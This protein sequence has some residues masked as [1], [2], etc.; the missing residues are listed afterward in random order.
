M[1]LKIYIGTATEITARLAGAPAATET[2]IASVTSTSAFT[3]ASAT[4]LSAGTSLAIGKQHGI[5]D[6]IIGNLVN[7]TFPLQRTPMMGD[8]VKIYDADYTEYRDQSQPFTFVD[9]RK[10][11]GNTGRLTSQDL[12]LF[13][14]DG[15]MVEPMEQSRIAIFESAD[16]T[17]P[18]FAGVITVSNRTPVALNDQLSI[19][20]LI[21]QWQVTAKGYQAEADGVGIEEQP[22][23]RINAGVYLDY[24]RQKYTNLDIGY[25]DKVNSPTINFIR[26]GNFRRFSELG[27]ALANFWPGAEFFIENDHTR[28]KVYFRQSSESVAP[29]ALTIDKIKEIGFVDSRQY[30][31]INRDTE[32]VFNVVLLP[33]YREQYREPDFHVQT[34]TANE[35]FLKTSVTLSG[36]PAAIEESLLLF[37]DFSDGSLSEDWAE[38]DLASNPSPP[39]GF[40]SSDGYLVE[41]SINGVQGLHML[42][43]SAV[44]PTV[45]LGDIGR[46]TDPAV[47][48]PFTG[49]ERQVLFMQELVI[50]T[51]GECVI[52][53]VIDLTTV[54]TATISGSTAS[55]IQVAS[56]SG[57]SVDDRIDV[58]GQK[59]FIQAIG[60]NYFDLYTAIVGAPAS[61]VTVTKHRLAKSRIQFG[62]IAKANG[63]LKYIKN[64]VETAFAVPRT[65]TATTYSF[66]VY[67]R[68]FES[69]ITGSPTNSSC[70]LADASNFTTGDVVLISSRG[71]SWPPERRVITKAGSTISFASLTYTPSAGYRVQA[72]PKIM[73]E[74]KGGTFGS[75]TGRDWTTVYQDAN[76]WQ[77]GEEDRADLS[78][79]IAMNASMV[80][81]VSFINMKDPIPITANIES[82]Y[83]HIGTQEV[84]SSEKDVDCIIR[85]VG[86]HFQ[87]D[88]FQDT[89]ALWA[90][91]KTLELRYKERWRVH[92]ES[93]DTA[94]IIALARQRGHAVDANTDQ[95]TLY[96]LGGRV[97][98]TIEISPST[99]TDLEAINQSNSLLDAVSITP[100]VVEILT[101][102]HAD[103]LCRSGQ[104]LPSEIEGIPNLLIERVEITEY[105]G[106][107]KDTGES[108][109]SQR[110]IAGT[111]DRLSQILQKRNLGSGIR[112]VIDDGYDDDTFTR[113]AKLNLSD[114][115]TTSDSFNTDECSSPTSV[116]YNSLEFTDLMCLRLS[117]SPPSSGLDIGPLL[118]NADNSFWIAHM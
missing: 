55:R 4:G 74:V 98:D 114:S 19:P 70:D 100:T 52:M 16:A 33:Y 108:V 86:S 75:I 25:I 101:S 2:T 115:V 83:L 29:L 3:V 42:D 87:L 43:T 21:Y 9:D 63:D 18:L 45:R 110:I 49:V 77:T 5:I 111:I 112:L 7:L 24:I 36:Q 105:Q 84:D 65:Y 99:L 66:R 64:G 78:V 20:T 8:T 67:M 44:S 107:K 11:G 61:G 28:G 76:T 57:F 13:D 69:T 41:G 58:G 79:F 89:K 88:F 1:T 85:K 102:T 59:G 94:A 31:K 10:T 40:I 54:V 22:F 73:A 23:T 62:I 46:V 82:R 53:G 38:D 60:V 15:L 81:T 113:L 37:D 116:I 91:G 27:I 96:K 56:T 90:S 93:P 103:E 47:V 106:I 39:T 118:D 30:V 97:L 72:M 34:T 26:I 48:E 12:I 68:S 35:A 117:D 51:L 32:N 109:Y 80:G 50:N 71:G 6:T 14:K 92:L 95:A 104:T 17:R